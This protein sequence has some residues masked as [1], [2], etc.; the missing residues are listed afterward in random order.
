MTDFPEYPGAPPPLDQR[1]AGPVRIGLNIRVMMPGSRTSHLKFSA[2]RAWCGRFTDRMVDPPG[3]MPTCGNC[4]T[5]SA[6]AASGLP[7]RA[8][9]KR[10]LTPAQDALF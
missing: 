6:R 1:I 2:D 7:S 10:R 5:S 9:P 4:V 8:R 3:R